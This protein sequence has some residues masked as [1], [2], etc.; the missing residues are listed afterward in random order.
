MCEKCEI[1]LAEEMIAAGV[2]EVRR[3]DNTKEPLDVIVARIYATMSHVNQELRAAVAESLA[4][5]QTN[6]LN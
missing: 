1:L 6:R 4:L 5:R 3:W 2:D